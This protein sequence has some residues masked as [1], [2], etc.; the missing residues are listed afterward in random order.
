VTADGTVVFNA[1][2]YW[3]K[4]NGAMQGLKESG[5]LFSKVSQDTLR[6]LVS[7]FDKANYFSLKDSYVREGCPDVSTDS[8][9]AYTSIQINGRR[10]AISH[11]LGCVFAEA[12]HETYP[13][14]L[15]TLE[16]RIDEIVKTQQWM[17]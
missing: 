8:P 7:E 3:V 12:N 16:N 2:A 13:R 1:T 6:Q 4:K 14:E 5:V 17:Q 10:K 15:T 11:Y 9:S